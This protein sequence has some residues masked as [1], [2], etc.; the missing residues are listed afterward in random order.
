L[1]LFYKVTDRQ[2]LTFGWD[3]GLLIG[4]QRQGTGE[5]E[6]CFSRNLDSAQTTVGYDKGFDQDS[7]AVQNRAA[8]LLK[9]FP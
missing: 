8:W 9:S 5:G 2:T 6:E 1:V 7:P 4:D 3:F